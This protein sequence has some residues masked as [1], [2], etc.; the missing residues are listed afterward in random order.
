MSLSRKLPRARRGRGGKETAGGRG[1][2]FTAETLVL[3]M[4]TVVVVV[5]VVVVVPVV[6]VVQVDAMV[7]VPDTAPA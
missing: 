5:V 3:G 4:I 2:L 6:V 1:A 7:I